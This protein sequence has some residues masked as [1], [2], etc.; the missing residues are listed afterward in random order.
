MVILGRS[1]VGDLL[2]TSWRL[3]VF[4]QSSGAGDGPHDTH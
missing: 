4:V 1:V 2:G 3:S